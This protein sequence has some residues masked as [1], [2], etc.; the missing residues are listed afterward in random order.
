M[1][2]QAHIAVIVASIAASAATLWLALAPAFVPNHA[3]D[4][5]RVVELPRVVVAAAR[6]PRVVELPRVVIEAQRATAGA[7]SMAGA[8]GPLQP[9]MTRQPN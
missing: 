6:E 4:G 9:V 5:L 7:A 2:R 3:T 1:Q 8:N